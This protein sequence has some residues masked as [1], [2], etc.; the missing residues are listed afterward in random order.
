MEDTSFVTQ[1][2]FEQQILELE[3]VKLNMNFHPLPGQVVLL[4]PYSYDKPL[5]KGFEL[6]DVLNRIK[7][8]GI[9]I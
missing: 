4:P 9:V 6:D 2:E 8:L 7:K 1:D 3:Q 5:P